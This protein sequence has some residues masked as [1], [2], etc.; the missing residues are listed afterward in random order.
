[1]LR[2]ECAPNPRI[3]NRKWTVHLDAQILSPDS[4]SPQAIDY[5]KIFLV[6]IVEY[7]IQLRVDKQLIYIDTA[8]QY[9][10]V[11]VNIRIQRLLQL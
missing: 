8:Q 7:S 10:T 6:R 11:T 3:I 2:V 4:K 1:M 5:I 9:S